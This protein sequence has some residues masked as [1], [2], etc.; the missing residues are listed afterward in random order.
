MQAHKYLSILTLNGSPLIFI[1]LINS[2]VSSVFL[3]AKACL[4][5]HDI[6]SLNFISLY[7]NACNPSSV[8]KSN[9]INLSL[10][11]TFSIALLASQFFIKSI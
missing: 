1:E 3:L 4:L 8:L 7:A 10:G 6:F 9:I 5:N 11:T 2:S